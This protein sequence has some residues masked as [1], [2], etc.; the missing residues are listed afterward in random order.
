MIASIKKKD[1]M[2]DN[3]ENSY[4]DKLMKEAQRNRIDIKVEEERVSD[5]VTNIK[6]TA[7]RNLEKVGKVDLT[8]ERDKW[9]LKSIYVDLNKD[10]AGRVLTK[11]IDK[12]KEICRKGE[13]DGVA[14][15]LLTYLNFNKDLLTNKI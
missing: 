13:S 2:T 8:K 4:Y 7:Q 12:V 5:E 6:I 1:G 3:I 9:R 11:L 10:K 14:R 15:D